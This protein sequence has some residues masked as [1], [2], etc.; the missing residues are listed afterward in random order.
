[1]AKVKIDPAAV[2]KLL[3]SPEVGELI[4]RSTRAIAAAAG[5]GMEAN[6]HLGATRWRGSV[7]TATQEAREAQARDQ[8]LMRAL[9]AGRF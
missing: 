1:M 8:A 2:G 7:I 4:G 3:K 5:P 6:T 9:D